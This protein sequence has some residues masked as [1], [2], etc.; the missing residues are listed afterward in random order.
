MIKVYGKENCPNCDKIKLELERI[1]I[2]FEYIKDDK[3]ATEIALGLRSDGK[4]IEMI[5]P[6]VVKD[7]LQI[8]H[9]DIEKLKKG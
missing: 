3:L 7:G 6:I 9:K 2:E 1:G 8:K 4:L 5:A